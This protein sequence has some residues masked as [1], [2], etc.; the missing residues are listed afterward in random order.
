M[1]FG[2]YWAREL[3]TQGHE[4]KLMPAQYVKRGKNDAADAE[5]ICE[6]VTRPTMR[7][8]GVKTSSRVSWAEAR[9]PQAPGFCDR[10]PRRVNL[11]SFK[12]RQL[13]EKATRRRPSK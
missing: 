3:T 9:D 4:V 10:Q 8:V 7:F 6:A 1:T 13:D 12:A 5:A 2:Y 11:S